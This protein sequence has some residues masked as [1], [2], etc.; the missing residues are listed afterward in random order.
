MLDVG[1]VVLVVA[2]RDGDAEP[3]AQGPPAVGRLVVTVEGDGGGL[4]VEF[5]E[6]DSELADRVRHD[7]QCERGDIGVEEPVE[8]SADAIVVERRE[9][10]LGQSQQF[11]SMPRGPLAD[12]IEG[13]ARSR[14]S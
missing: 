9:L 8:A 1:S 14:Y 13:L 5:V 2:V 7:G 4:V 11:R 6:L 10:R 12:T 3:P